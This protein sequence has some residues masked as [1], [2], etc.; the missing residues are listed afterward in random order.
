MV[1]T[2]FGSGNAIATTVLT[3]RYEMV[4]L[5]YV[6]DTF[7]DKR[8]LIINGSMEQM[9]AFYEALKDSM[10]TAVNRDLKEHGITDLAGVHHC[11]CPDDDLEDWRSE[12]GE[13]AAYAKAKAQGIREGLMRFAAEESRFTFEGDSRSWVAALEAA[14]VATG[15]ELESEAF[16]V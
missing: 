9:C 5:E 13:I 16:V 2:N 10:E 7:R 14:I 3:G 6:N 11:P 8:M 15:I 12:P 1:K 4:R